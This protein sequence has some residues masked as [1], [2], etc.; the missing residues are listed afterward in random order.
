MDV[1]HS[2]RRK[3]IVQHQVYSFKVDS[4]GE[5]SRTDQHPDVTRAKTVHYIVSLLRSSHR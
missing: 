2:A 5:Q 3:V 4:S 1:L